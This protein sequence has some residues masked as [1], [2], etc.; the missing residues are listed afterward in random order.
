M[1]CI[2]NVKK[3]I[4]RN[5]VKAGV[6]S[7]ASLVVIGALLQGEWSGFNHTFVEQGHKLNTFGTQAPIETHEANCTEPCNIT[8]PVYQDESSMQEM[9]DATTAKNTSNP[10]F[11]LHVGP[12]YVSNDHDFRCHF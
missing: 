6:F 11:L 4:S 2:V 12:G 3:F 5:G 9:I 8:S 10:V 7:L 1:Q